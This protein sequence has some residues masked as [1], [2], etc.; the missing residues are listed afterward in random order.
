MQCHRHQ[1]R[2]AGRRCYRC[3]EPICSTCQVRAFHHLFCSSH[4]ILFYR[5]QEVL[6][7]GLSSF[8]SLLAIPPIR[9]TGAQRWLAS[10][11]FLASLAIFVL[12]SQQRTSSLRVLAKF[13]SVQPCYLKSPIDSPLAV[14]LRPPY[15]IGSASAQSPPSVPPKPPASVN[16]ARPSR[17]KGS[18]QHALCSS[19]KEMEGEVERE[20]APDI[21]RGDLHRKEIALTFDGGGWANAAPEILDAVREKGISCTFFLT[22]EFIRRYPDVVKQM[23]AEGHEVANHTENHLHL[24]SF[25]ANSRHK[26]LPWVN[27][28]FLW[29]ELR[30][31][32]QL[33]FELTGQKMAPFW[34]AP[35]GE[36]NATLR[37]WAKEMGYQH[38]SWTSG[39]RA[40]KSLDSLDWVA[41][42]SLKIYCSA[43]DVRNRILG[44]GDGANDGANGGIVLMHLGTS[45]M[46]DRVHE[47]LGEI[48]EGLREKGYRLVKVSELLEAREVKKGSNCD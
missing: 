39:Y 22:G 33:F 41:D 12:S 27:R 28:R 30:G 36:Q 31:A 38:V 40:R 21:S 48:I 7:L 35:Y 32:E 5:F 45:R 25:A 3:H 14:D 19:E 6:H 20:E 43:E 16:Q 17:H 44:F 9:A 42:P 23:V 29:R 37:R 34:R 24:T 8:S 47:R 46:H 26:L 18:S 4:C 15:P 11:V 2:E 13:P 10:L 1:E